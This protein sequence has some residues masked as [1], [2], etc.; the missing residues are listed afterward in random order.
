MPG[1][2]KRR[3]TT[4]HRSR[5]LIY[6]GSLEYQCAYVQVIAIVVASTDYF[7]SYLREKYV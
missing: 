4:D 2:S 6:H 1:N 7:S 5:H 3:N